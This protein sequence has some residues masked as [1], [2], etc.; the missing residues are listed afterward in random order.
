MTNTVHRVRP[1]R[2]AVELKL[3]ERTTGIANNLG[4]LVGRVT[5]RA[6]VGGLSHWAHNRLLCIRRADWTNMKLKVLHLTDEWIETTVS[7]RYRAR[8]MHDDIPIHRNV[9]PAL[10]SL[11]PELTILLLLGDVSLL[12]SLKRFLR[13]IGRLEARDTIHGDLDIFTAGIRTRR[14]WRDR[15]GPV[16]V[17]VMV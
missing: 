2:D 16:G 10:L 12:G 8:V 7:P 5:L 9:H 3:G 6:R 4:C 11:L 13:C 14:K 15:I 1:A 17:V